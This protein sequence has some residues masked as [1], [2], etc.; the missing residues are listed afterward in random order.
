VSSHLCA[1]GGDN[2]VRPR[3][4]AADRRIGRRRKKKKKRKKEK[5]KTNITTQ[6][7][8]HTHC[9]RF[10]GDTGYFIESNRR[11]RAARSFIHVSIS[12]WSI[13]DVA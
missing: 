4:W 12:M 1:C 6:R 11:G 7:V 9:V 2:V 5:K 13:Y 3:R 8:R 10:I